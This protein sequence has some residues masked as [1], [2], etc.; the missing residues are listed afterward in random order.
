MFCSEVAYH[1]SSASRSTR[2]TVQRDTQPEAALSLQQVHWP[3]PRGRPDESNSSSEDQT[4]Y[5]HGHSMHSHQSRDGGPV[6]PR[7]QLTR[8]LEVG[9]PE[10]ACLHERRK[11]TGLQ[12][13]TPESNAVQPVQPPWHCRA[14]RLHGKISQRHIPER[15]CKQLSAPCTRWRQGL[16]CFLKCDAISDGLS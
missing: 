16:D 10:A 1:W 3:G 12:D 15:C 9:P 6:S 14:F 7:T 8:N 11:R 2:P 4:A 5:E 13:I